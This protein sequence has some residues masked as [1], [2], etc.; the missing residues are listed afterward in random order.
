MNMRVLARAT[1]LAAF[2]STSCFA[3]SK[4]TT[5]KNKIDRRAFENTDYTGLIVHFKSGETEDKKAQKLQSRFD[6]FKSRTGR[7]VSFERN[8]AGKG[9][10]LKIEKGT[11]KSEVLELAESIAEDVDVEWV[12]PNAHFYPN[13]NDTYYNLQYHLL[14]TSTGIDAVSAWS[15]ATGNG[16]T[17]AVVD[18]G[19]SAHS[20][21]AA[22]EVPGYDFVSDSTRAR[23]GNGRD[24]NPTD[25]GD[26]CTNPPANSTW[27]GTQVAGVIGAITNNNQGVA[28]VAYDVD[29]MHVR[30]IASCAGNGISSQSYATLADIEAAIIWASGGFVSG[31][32]TNSNPADV[33]NL[34]LG[35]QFACSPSMQFAIDTATANGSVVVAAAGNDNL[36][37][38]THTPANCNNVIAVAASDSSGNKASFSNFNNVDI[39]APGVGILTTSNFGAQSAGSES[40]AGPNG[41]SFSSPQAAA[42]AAL[43]LE[44][45]PSLS[46]SDVKTGIMSSAATLPGTC[47]GG[48]GAGLL[49]AAAAVTWAQNQPSQTTCSDTGFETKVFSQT[50]SATNHIHDMVV[51]VPSDYVVIGGG[52]RGNF[53]PGNFIVSS[54]PNSS[55]TGWVVSTKDHIYASTT[56]ITGYAIGLKVNGLTAAQLKSYI[57]RDYQGSDYDRFSTI[58]SSTGLLTLSGGADINW[59]GWG[60]LLYQSYPTY[61]SSG[62]ITE[63]TSKGREHGNAAYHNIYGYTLRI[64]ENIPGIGQFKTVVNSATSAVTN[65]AEATATRPAGTQLVACGFKSNWTYGVG[66]GH[67]AWK[68]YPLTSG[69][70]PVSC[71][72]AAKDLKYA[73]Y[74]SVTAYA[75]GL[76]LCN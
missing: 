64:Q 10:L 53:N 63:W 38:S 36:D 21:T 55:L 49:D 17:V 16:I 51:S 46:V 54:Y 33:I 44:A 13:T 1:V 58:S 24:S 60:G 74:R 29:L 66:A 57:T 70:T 18:S 8:L 69:T 2:F 28:S 61:N 62:E 35:T 73:D 3:E 14:N 45:N 37:A 12:E 19:T 59:T 27:H 65:W 75:V 52:V 42:V 5:H 72:A 9:K 26:Y 31:V 4:E 6:R 20:D 39:T 7:N 48:C 32:P 23:D 68:S 43:M 41:T 15:S 40:Y 30:V 34:S 50:S 56:P 11:S 71:N 76:Q 25:E 22:N 47:S 67:V